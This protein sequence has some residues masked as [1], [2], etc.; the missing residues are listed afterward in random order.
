[1]KVGLRSTRLLHL[2][3]IIMNHLSRSLATL[4]A[5]TLPLFAQKVEYVEPYRPFSESPAIRDST[6]GE[7]DPTRTLLVPLITWAADGVTVSANGGLDPDPNSPLARAMGGAVQLE[8]ID[9]FDKQVANYVTG[10]SP[11]L[12][13]TADMIALVSQAL[14]SKDPALEPVVFLQLSTSTG[15]DGFVGVDIDQLA[16]LKGKSIALQLNGPHLSLVGNLIKDAGL[17]PTDVTL[18]FVREITAPP[19][20]DPD[21][22]A[23][24]PANAL[25]RD[26]SLAGAAM[27]FPDIL[28]TTGG[29]TGT[30]QEGTVKGARPVFT[31]KTADNVIFDVYAVRRD[32]LT[33][34]P[35]IVEGFRQ[36]QLAK[37][38]EFLA[39]LANVAKKNDA[40]R[41]QVDAFKTA[42]RP[43]AG[44]FLQDEGAV[45]DFILWVGVD[46]RLAGNSGNVKFFDEKNSVG[47]RATTDRIQSFLTEI[48]LIASPTQIAFVAPAAS[49][50]PAPTKAAK[51]S[52]AS[53][54]AVRAAAESQDASTLYR[55][56]FQFPAAMSDMSWQDY[57]DVF[58]KIH[59]TVARYGGAIVQLQ[60]HADNFFANFVAAKR[61]A[62]ETTYERRNRTTGDFDKLPLPKY[63]ELLND[64]NTLS[65]SRAFAVKK[66][67]AAY[68][69]ESLKLSPNEIDL[70]RFDVRGMGISEPVITNPT[71]P[72]ERAQN[73]RGEMVIIAAESEIPADFGADD[74]R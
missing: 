63:E 12:R 2:A 35:E 6:K 30:G 52:F 27:I 41:R 50:E 23:Q 59:E 70:S 68:V 21:E 57:P 31:T 56:T 54:Q 14:K 71:T 37:Q 45:N 7:V 29:G 28:A 34:H 13:G 9:D 15:A 69:R 17:A 72:E 40:N 8:V 26:P 11:F 55:Y 20:W 19:G 48:G 46:S 3:P 65:Y 51:Q 22:A 36:A 24:D 5:T 4:L 62:G 64:A 53:A 44:I 73:M 60:G 66:A 58:A 74:L 43:L 10:K 18:K 1:M 67:Y 39:E 42:C 38:E 16:D 33:D 32:F 49:A 25:R 47:L 61:K